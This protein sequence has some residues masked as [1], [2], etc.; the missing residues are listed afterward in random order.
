M[1][2]RAAHA[3]AESAMLMKTVMMPLLAATLLSACG[4]G[5]P[6][7]R[8][9]PVLRNAPPARS[10][11]FP[12]KIES[13]SAFTSRKKL[14]FGP[15][16]LYRV[17]DARGAINLVV[18]GNPGYSVGQCMTLWRSVSGAQWEMYHDYSN[19]YPR[20][21]RANGDC[22]ALKIEPSGNE[23]Y[24]YTQ[25]DWNWNQIETF[26]RDIQLG[27]T[28]AELLSELGAPD[29]SYVNGK[30]TYLS[31]TRASTSVYGDVQN[32]SGGFSSR[33]N[34]CKRTFMVQAGIIVN[35]TLEGNDCRL[36]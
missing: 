26:I 7:L 12:V 18:S 14:N 19:A 35:Y 20:L 36:K 5:A 34:F 22:S 2:P 13:K 3:E 1:P 6:R 10:K 11:S 9:A 31:Y 25:Y 30:T 16:T 15:L 4:S 33:Q 21:T 32:G 24:Y 8:E 28:E 17:R 23:R 27:R 29:A